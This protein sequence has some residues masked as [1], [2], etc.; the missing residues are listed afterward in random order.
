[1]RQDGLDQ[2]SVIVDRD[3]L[4]SDR[5]IIVIVIEAHRQP[6][7]H[8]CRDLARTPAPLLLRVPLQKP[9][10][11]LLAHMRQS[12]LLEVARFGGRRHAKP[13]NESSRGYQPE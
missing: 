12:F 3:A 4:V 10:L 11:Q 7:Q 8:G 2:R 1:M 5:V 9:L 13:L 6:I